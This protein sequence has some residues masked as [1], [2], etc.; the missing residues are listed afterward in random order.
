MR[1]AI[2]VALLLIL[3]SCGTIKFVQYEQPGEHKTTKRWHHAALNGLVELSPPLDVRQVCGNKAWTNI[4]TERTFAN[5]FVGAFM[6]S[7][8]YVALYVPWTNKVEC[9]ESPKETEN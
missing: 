9:F 8:P 1:K 4:T 3:S 5:I 7:T 6:P 2:I